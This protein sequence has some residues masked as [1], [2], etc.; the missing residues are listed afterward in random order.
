M[1]H[2]IW[3]KTH[4]EQRGDVPRW[5]S[6]RND[7]YEE[8][9]QEDRHKNM[10]R[11]ILMNELDQECKVLSKYEVDIN[12]EY[13]LLPPSMCLENEHAVIGCFELLAK[14]IT[15]KYFNESTYFSFYGPEVSIFYGFLQRIIISRRYFI[16]C[17]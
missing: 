3:R 11:N 10:A 7:E 12:N 6:I 4:K 14:N 2:Q 15:V 1:M 17:F 13:D 9:Y 5:K 16:C 8:W